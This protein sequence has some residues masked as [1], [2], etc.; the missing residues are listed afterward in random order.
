[1]QRLVAAAI[2]MDQQTAVALVHEHA[3]GVRQMG[4]EASRV[5]DGT[6]GDDE[7]HRTS[8]TVSRRAARGKSATECRPACAAAFPLALR[9]DITPP[10]A[11]GA[12]VSDTTTR[13][14]MLALLLVF[15]IASILCVPLGRLI[16]GRVF[17]VA[18]LVPL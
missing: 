12:P 14:P 7:A 9:I 6:A 1:V 8:L 13:R 2:R 5:I 3:C 18:T 4:V 11:V 16:G 10:P 15:A 17:Y